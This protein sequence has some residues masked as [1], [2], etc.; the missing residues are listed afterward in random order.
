MT[1]RSRPPAWRRGSTPAACDPVRWRGSLTLVLGG[2]PDDVQPSPTVEVCA[3]LAEWLVAPV[4]TVVEGGAPWDDY[5][6]E[7]VILD[8]TGNERVAARPRPPG[9][10]TSGGSISGCVGLV[11]DVTARP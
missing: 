4:V 5:E 3:D 2:D 8:S 1:S 10:R 6:L 7:R 9:V 11:A